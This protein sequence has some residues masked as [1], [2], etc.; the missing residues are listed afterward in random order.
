MLDWVVS[1]DPSTV[2]DPDMACVCSW[3]VIPTTS[4]IIRHGI[5]EKFP[6]RILAV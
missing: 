5:G 6:R 2:N 3:W 4:L 1:V